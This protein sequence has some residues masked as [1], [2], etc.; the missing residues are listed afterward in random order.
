MDR[1]ER[2][3]REVEK[4]LQCFEQAERLRGDPFF[5]TRLRARIDKLSG[6]QGGLRGWQGAW[7]LVRTT[8]LVL[9]VALNIVT[10]AFYL[11]T[12]PLEA[13]E[14]SQLLS[15]FA[16]EYALAQDESYSYGDSD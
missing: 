12:D 3:K 9:L 4:T 14:R 8:S 15:A 1:E 10:A 16:Q 7:G 2:I 13:D 6:E 5:Y 11:K